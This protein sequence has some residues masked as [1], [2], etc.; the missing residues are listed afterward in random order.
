MWRTRRVTAL[1]VPTP[2]WWP[3]ELTSLTLHPHRQLVV[4]VVQN[5]S[6]LIFCAQVL[7]DR[8]LRVLM[9]LAGQKSKLE[10]SGKGASTS[11]I[12]AQTKSDPMSA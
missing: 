3:Y 1:R 9:Q 12:A 8:L 7:T 2:P 10:V 6:A 11:R 5:R 4:E